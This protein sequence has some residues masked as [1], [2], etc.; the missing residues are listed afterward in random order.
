[1]PLSTVRPDYQ[2]ELLTKQLKTFLGILDQDSIEEITKRLHWVACV[3]GETLMSQGEP[4]DSLYMVVSGRMRVY[5]N[6]NII[7][8]IARGEVVGEMSLF[9]NEPRSA[10]LIAIRD[11]VLVKLNRPDFEHLLATKPEVS[12]AL[13]K[14]IIQRL[15]TEQNRGVIDKP[16]TMALVPISEGTDVNGLA[17][18]L[19][20]ELESKGRV[21][22]LDA[23]DY[24]E[25]LSHTAGTDSQSTRDRVNS[26]ALALD[27]I[28]SRHDFVLLVGEEV[29]SEWTQLCIRHAD[30]IML[31]ADADAPPQL[32]PTELESLIN[33]PQRAEAAEVLVLLH[34]ADKFMPTGTSQWLARRPVAD[35]IHVRPTLQKDIARLGRIQSRTASG[36][37]LAGGGARGFA[38]LGIYR[39]LNEMGVEVDFVG[40]TSIGAVMAAFVASDH[41]PVTTEAIARKAFLTNP[42]SDFTLLPLISLFKGVKLRGIVRAS[43]REAFGPNVDIEDL[44]KGYYCVATNYSKASEVVFQ[45]GELVRSI[46]CS[47]AIPGALPPVIVDGD[48]MSD[49]G[50]FNNF[51]VDVM[52]HRRGVGKVIGVDLNNSK[53]RRIE[54]DEVPSPWQLLRDRFRPRKS[55]RYRLPSLAVLLINTTILY[56]TSRQKQAKALT[57]IYF[58][59]PLDRVGMLDWHSF[60][61]VVEQGYAHAKEILTATAKTECT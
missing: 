11:T 23:S 53:V 33:R 18:K 15:Q 54:I 59:P 20:K 21:S 8:E 58:N 14:Q 4:G 22:L 44:W 48:L 45:R 51:P 36:L 52:R 2:N 25:L 5:F 30:E 27:E 32:H 3:G 60:D 6:D 43:A 31:L 9:T 47:I 55:R 12:K 49:G 1:M 29:N 50:T 42:T 19:A 16:V 61:K 35:H 56:S 57:D 17:R 26:V 40:G 7:R 37:V 38:H 24:Q 13:T 10:T 28:E 39:A 46:L 34:R 41:P